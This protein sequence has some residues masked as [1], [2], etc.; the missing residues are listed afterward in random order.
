[1]IRKMTGNELLRIRKIPTWAREIILDVADWHH[2]ALREVLTGYR[3]K[4]AVIARDD[5]VYRLRT[6]G[7]RRPSTMQIGD[8]VGLDDST[9]SV[10]LARHSERTGAKI[11]TNA[12]LEARRRRN[13]EYN[14]RRA[15]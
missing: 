9:V 3:S 6:E 2:V 7:P 14:E 15:A 1:M 11:I 12:D 13:K 10:A 4:R 5:A 8:W